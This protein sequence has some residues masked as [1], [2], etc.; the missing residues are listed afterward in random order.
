MN[1][2]E[3]NT[4]PSDRV[5]PKTES[6]VEIAPPTY[7]K[8][9]TSPSSFIFDALI[10]VVILAVFSA[11][12]LKYFKAPLKGFFKNFNMRARVESEVGVQSVRLS[13]KTMLHIVE[14]QGEK[15]FVAESSVNVAFGNPSGSSAE[16]AVSFDSSKD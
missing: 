5:I 4:S 13:P 9:L 14:Y 2:N 10:F 12:M 3:S 6:L 16:N 15:L 11:L 1:E 8:E 7:K